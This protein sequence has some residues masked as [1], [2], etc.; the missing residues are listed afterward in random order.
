MTPEYHSVGHP[1]AGYPVVGTSKEEE[2]GKK[3]QKEAQ[4]EQEEEEE[5]EEE[6]VGAKESLFCWEQ[7]SFGSGQTLVSL[8]SPLGT[9]HAQTAVFCS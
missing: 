3:G 1:A 5:E 2:A 8:V 6:G 7:A 4:E 9:Q